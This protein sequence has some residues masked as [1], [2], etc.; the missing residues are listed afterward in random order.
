MFLMLLLLNEMTGSA[1]IQE[2][3]SPSLF[4][5]VYSCLTLSVQ[6]IV[7]SFFYLSIKFSL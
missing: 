5:Q 2:A 1:N 4:S 3:L 6:S 7:L